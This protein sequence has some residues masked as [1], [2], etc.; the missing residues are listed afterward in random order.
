MKKIMY[1]LL[2]G[3]SLLLVWQLAVIIF[4]M[5]DYILPS[6]AQV[7]FSMYE[8]RVILIRHAVPTF[9]E[10][11]AG[12]VLGTLLGAAAGCLLALN[13][14]LSRLFLPILI[15]SQVT[16][17]FAIA[18][19]LVIWFGFGIASK[20]SA[21]VIMIFFPVASALHDGLHRTNRG[22]MELASTMQASS[23]ATFWHIQLRAALPELASGIRIAAVA[24]PVGAVIGEWVGA[25][26]G[27]GYLMLNANARMQIDTMFASL[28]VIIMM[29]L[30]LYWLIDFTLK[31]IIWWQE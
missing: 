7:M 10:T 20:I 1:A 30:G 14:T 24:A 31:K 4:K 5:P 6:P 26:Q 9:G 13:R 25:S 15:I 19:L 12:L 22:W 27:L 8:Q 18:P 29:S 28:I 23:G 11:L 21:A 2:T 16:P 3:I 17:V